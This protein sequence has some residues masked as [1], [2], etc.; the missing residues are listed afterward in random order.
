MG[1]SMRGRFG[2]LQGA[3]LPPAGSLPTDRIF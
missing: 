3:L 2:L 1:H